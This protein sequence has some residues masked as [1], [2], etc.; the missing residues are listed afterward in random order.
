MGSASC[1]ANRPSNRVGTSPT[2]RHRT[3]VGATWAG[4]IQALDSKGNTTKGDSWE[5][6]NAVYLLCCVYS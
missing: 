3:P 2:L 1:L 6:R 5:K 4:P